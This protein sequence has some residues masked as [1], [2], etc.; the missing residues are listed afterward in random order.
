MFR[1]ITIL[2]II[3]FLYRLLSRYILPIFRIT[4]VAS[5]QMRQMQDKMKEMDEKMNQQNNQRD[6]NK[7]VKKEG[8][9][10][11]YEEVKP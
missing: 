5:G 2:F 6:T 10:I 3:G 7:K 1:I 4:S 11:D 9:Y 8:D